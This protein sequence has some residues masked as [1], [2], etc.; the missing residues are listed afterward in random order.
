MKNKIGAVLLKIFLSFIALIVSILIANLIWKGL[1][2]HKYGSA[3]LP[4]LFFAGLVVAVWF[5]APLAKRAIAACLGIVA[6]LMVWSLSFAIPSS[7]PATISLYVG[8]FRAAGMVVSFLVTLAL[9]K[10]GQKPSS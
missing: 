1:L 10:R 5:R 9:L 7:D 2:G 6:G 4:E 3:T 8:I